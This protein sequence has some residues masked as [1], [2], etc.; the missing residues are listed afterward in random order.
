VFG[1]VANVLSQ[2]S[3]LGLHFPYESQ[4]KLV[5]IDEGGKHTVESTSIP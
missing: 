3:I 4:G 1:F 2:A 5:H